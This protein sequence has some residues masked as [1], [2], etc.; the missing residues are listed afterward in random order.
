[1]KRQTGVF[2]RVQLSIMTGVIAAVIASDHTAFAGTAN[3]KGSE[4][5]SFVTANFSTMASRPRFWVSPLVRITSADALSARQYP[6]LPLAQAV[7]RRLTA[8]QVSP[9]SSYMQPGSTLTIKVSCIPT[10]RSAPTALAVQD[11]SARPSPFPSRAERKI[12]LMRQVR[13][14]RSSPA[15]NSP[16]ATPQDNCS[17][18]A[19]LPGPGR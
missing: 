11:P 17:A 2:I 15:K 16:Q 1:M 14:L 9:S 13:S 18:A 7:V 3:V 5:G 4:V 8:A 6:K 19:R 12:S 10:G